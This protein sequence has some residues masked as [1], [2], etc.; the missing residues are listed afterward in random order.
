MIRGQFVFRVSGGP[1]SRLEMA[2]SEWYLFRRL[3]TLSKEGAQIEWFESAGCPLVPASLAALNLYLRSGAMRHWRSRR[4]DANRELLGL[5][6]WRRFVRMLNLKFDGR[7]TGPD[8]VGIVRRIGQRRDAT[9]APHDGTAKSQNPSRKAGVFPSLVM[10]G[11]G[12][13]K[14]PGPERSAGRTLDLSREMP[15]AAIS[16]LR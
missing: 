16:P 4:W 2:A 1:V 9:R 13:A 12:K 10:A 5:P 15:G 8:G 14:I 7:G 3:R 11:P 6:E